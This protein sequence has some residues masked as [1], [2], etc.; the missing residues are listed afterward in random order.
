MLTNVRF[1]EIIGTA[2]T[3]LSSMVGPLSMF[4]IGM[5]IGQGD[6]RRLLT[7]KK[8]YLIVFL[9]LIFYPLSVM[10]ILYVCGILKVFPALTPVFQ[11]VFF[12]LAAPPAAMVS[13]LA[14][15]Y[16]E[17]PVEAGNLNVMGTILCAVTI[18]LVLFIFEKAF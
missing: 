9:R 5:I 11:V 17:E 8:G 15:I 1:P 12:A 3:S 6:I 2:V 18:P 16:D 4:V 10:G 13:Q 7:F 14:L